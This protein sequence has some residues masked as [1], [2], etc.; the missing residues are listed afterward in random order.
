MG[1]VRRLQCLAAAS[2]EGEEIVFISTSFIHVLLTV[3]LAQLVSGATSLSLLA[4]AFALASK[5]FALA[6]WSEDENLSY[7]P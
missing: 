3:L 4:V 1:H 6:A 5:A 7:P 2:T